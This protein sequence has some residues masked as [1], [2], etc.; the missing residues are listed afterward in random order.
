MAKS[1]LPLIIGVGAAALILM[2]KKKK[3]APSNGGTG[4]GDP[5]VVDSGTR[6][7][8]WSWQVLKES[9]TGFGDRYFGEISA[10]NSGEW[11][12]IED[13]R[14]NAREAKLLALEA[15]AQVQAGA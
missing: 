14:T 9:Q 4:N 1:A 12:T 2:P 15:I 8:G 3:K 11:I 13:G 7:S 6:Q 5:R 10:P